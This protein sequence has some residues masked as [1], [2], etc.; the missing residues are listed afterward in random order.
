MWPTRNELR[1]EKFCVHVNSILLC[2]LLETWKTYAARAN[3]SS[4]SAETI[5]PLSVIDFQFAMKWQTTRNHPPILLWQKKRI[6]RQNGS[7]WKWLISVMISL[8]QFVCVGV[9]LQSIGINNWWKRRLWW[10]N[11][12]IAHDLKCLTKMNKCEFVGYKGWAWMRLCL[13]VG[14]RAWEHMYY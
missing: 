13:F 4:L 6:N 3:G 14:W 9:N 5:R 10:I 11:K 8:I 1:G 7:K 12:I 2:N